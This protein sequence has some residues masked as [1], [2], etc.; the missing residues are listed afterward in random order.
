MYGCEHLNWTWI[1][2]IIPAEELLILKVLYMCVDKEVS[3]LIVQLLGL[4]RGYKAV[5]SSDCQVCPVCPSVCSEQCDSQWTNFHKTSYLGF[6]I[7]FVHADF[8]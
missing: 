1:F 3:M 6:F 5:V 7:K 4:R 2:I 8:G